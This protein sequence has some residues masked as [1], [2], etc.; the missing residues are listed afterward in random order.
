MSR[1]YARYAC[2]SYVKSYDLNKEEGGLPN[3]KYDKNNET[4]VEHIN[5]R[6]KF[7]IGDWMRIYDSKR[8]NLGD[9]SIFL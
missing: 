1:T 5:L 3:G 7:E 9:G 6:P 8:T 2:T 4:F